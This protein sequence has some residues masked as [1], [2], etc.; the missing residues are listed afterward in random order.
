MYLI[1]K[2]THEQNESNNCNLMSE[3]YFLKWYF[4][5]LLLLYI[6]ELS[7]YCNQNHFMFCLLD[8]LNKIK[9]VTSVKLT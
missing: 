1:A 4:I 9:L 5:T 7:N 6:L 2:Y 8:S 3:S